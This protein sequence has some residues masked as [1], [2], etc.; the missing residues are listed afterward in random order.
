MQQ[1]SRTCLVADHYSK[2]IEYVCVYP[3]CLYSRFL[4]SKCLLE[5]NHKHDL[6]DSS[7]ILDKIDFYKKIENN[8]KQIK[9]K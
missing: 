2:V 3:Q 7:H 4:C 5:T 9:D 8:F 6:K 1:L